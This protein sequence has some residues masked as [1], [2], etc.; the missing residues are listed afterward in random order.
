MAGIKAIIPP[1]DADGNAV[2]RYR[3][4]VSV[5]LVGLIL[6]FS[7]HVALACGYLAT[8]FIAFP[9]FA[10]ADTVQNISAQIM[11]VKASELDS[12]IRTDI[13]AQC[14]AERAQNGVA[15]QF[16]SQRLEH[17]YVEWAKLKRGSYYVPSCKELGF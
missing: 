1:H 3:V 5:A 17:E 6:G 4:A 15:L 2:Y 8:T 10:R 9:G 13:N 14:A 12:D 7:I 16:I 11:D